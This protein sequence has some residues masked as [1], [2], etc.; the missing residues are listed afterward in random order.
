MSIKGEN[1]P[2]NQEIDL[3][4]MFKKVGNFFDWM[5]FS[6]FRM[7]QFFIKNAIVVAV[8]IAVG[9]GIGVYFKQSMNSYD[10][11]IIVSPN[12]KSTDYLYVKIDLLSSKIALKDTFFLKSIGIKNPMQITNIAV[13]PIRNVNNL[14]NKEDKGFQLLQLMQ[15]NEN[16]KSIIKDTTLNRNYTFHTIVITTTGMTSS[17]NTIE[18]VLNFLNTSAY[19][20]GIATINS[21]NIQHQIQSKEG[22][23]TQIDGILNKFSAINPSQSGNDKLVYYNENLNLDQVI[24]VKDSLSDQIGALK[25][26]LYNSDKIIKERGMILNIKKYK[27]IRGKLLFILPILFVGLFVFF[28]FFLSFYKKQSLKA[29]KINA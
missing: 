3:L 23:I 26:E 22:T 16:L 25:L 29:Q 21:R 11:K 12:F 14:I 15:E 18:P 20:D 9:F 27:S 4:V 1:H 19:Y 8:L 17:K 28:S 6:L 7:I 10:Q 5:S 13:G 2:E 24:N